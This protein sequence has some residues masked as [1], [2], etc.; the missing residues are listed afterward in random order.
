[1]YFADDHSRC[2]FLIITL[3]S[4]KLKCPGVEVYKL[5]LADPALWRAEFSPVLCNQLLSEN[6]LTRQNTRYTL[7]T[8]PPPPTKKYYAKKNTPL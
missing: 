5:Y 4:V 7:H 2:T 8:A 1:M 6:Q 3:T